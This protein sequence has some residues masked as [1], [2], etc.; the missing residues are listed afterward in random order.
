MPWLAAGLF[1]SAAGHASLL[2]T[3]VYLHVAVD[4]D[5]EVSRNCRAFR[6]ECDSRRRANTGLL[7]PGPIP[8]AGGRII[9][10]EGWRNVDGRSSLGLK[11]S[12]GISP[13]PRKKLG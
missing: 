9:P 13:V 5:G 8:R 11:L 6:R 12:T 1:R 2:T 3:S 7:F 4:D 10:C